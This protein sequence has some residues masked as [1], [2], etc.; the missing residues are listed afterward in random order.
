[1]LKFLDGNNKNIFKKIEN[2]STERKKLQENKSAISKKIVT[3]VKKNKDK[4][5]IKFEKRF[6]KIKNI[7]KRNLIF[8]NKK[9][10]KITKTLDK[11]TK[12][13][14]DMAYQRLKKFHLHQKLKSFKMKDSFKNVLE[15]KNSPIESVGIYV[16]GGTASYPSSV[17]MSCIPAIVAGVKKIYMSTPALVNKPNPAVIYAAIKCE[18]EKFIKW[19]VLKRLLGLHMELNNQKVEKIVG[20]GNAFV[21]SAKKEVFGDV[22]IDMIAGPSSNSC[23][24]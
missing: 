8:S 24:R 17:L 16:P 22:G 15:Y 12:K 18:L 2:I 20:P 7:N 14:I 10:K 9:I 11:E 4:A 19:E 21:V 1:M 5:I 6:N 3:Q 13:S 23:S